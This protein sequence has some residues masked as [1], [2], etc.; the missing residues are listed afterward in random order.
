MGFRVRCAAVEV[1]G[2]TALGDREGPGLGVPTILVL[3][4]G[5]RAHWARGML[6]LGPEISIWHSL[7][8]ECRDPVR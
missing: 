2:L 8:S 1:I 4:V 3:T 7:I 6:E 5:S